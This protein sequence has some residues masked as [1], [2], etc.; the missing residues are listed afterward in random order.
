M[1]WHLL[2]H[3]LVSGVRVNLFIDM[4]WWLLFEPEFMGPTTT[5]EFDDQL[6]LVR[7]R[8]RILDAE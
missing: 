1:D 8:D 2:T 3:I 6:R 7:S 5:I 4:I